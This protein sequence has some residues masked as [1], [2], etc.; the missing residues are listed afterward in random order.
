MVDLKQFSATELCEI[1]VG[2]RKMNKKRNKKRRAPKAYEMQKKPLTLNLMIDGKIIFR[3]E[4][5]C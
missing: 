2:R 4:I 5:Y 3:S 1:L